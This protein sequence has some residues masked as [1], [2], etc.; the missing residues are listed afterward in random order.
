MQ[1]TVGWKVLTDEMVPQQSYIA[2]YDL[3]LDIAKSVLTVENLS[4]IPD[5][6]TSPYPIIPILLSRE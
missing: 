1:W 3:T 4:T 2:S 6:G 5:K